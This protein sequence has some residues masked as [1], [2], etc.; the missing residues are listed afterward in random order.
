MSP[1]HSPLPFALL[2]KRISDVCISSPSPSPE[3]A[4]YQCREWRRVSHSFALRG[5][6]ILKSAAKNPAS[7]IFFRKSRMISPDSPRES[8]S[9]YKYKY[10]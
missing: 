4:D 6:Y 8:S 5:I 7:R 10:I 3:S 1:P 9:E 2:E